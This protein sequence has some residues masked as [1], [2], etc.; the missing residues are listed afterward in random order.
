M[1]FIT[2][3]GQKTDHGV[4]VIT[5]NQSLVTIKNITI[6][7]LNGTISKHEIRDDDHWKSSNP[8]LTNHQQSYVTIQNKA[9]FVIGDSADCEAALIAEGKPPKP[10]QDFIQIS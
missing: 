2:I 10:K 1:A 8:L 3:L 9:I 5:S 7:V 4:N 6:N